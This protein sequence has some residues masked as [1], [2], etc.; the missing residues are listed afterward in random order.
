[1]NDGEECKNTKL[2]NG[3]KCEG[4]VEK[5][6]KKKTINPKKKKKIFLYKK[7]KKKKT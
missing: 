6:E 1:M 5:K 3:V 2:D 7:I 4:R